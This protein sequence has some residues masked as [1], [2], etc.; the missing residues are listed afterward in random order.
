MK[1][2]MLVAA[3]ELSL[4]ADNVIVDCRFNLADKGE[5]ERLYHEGHI[6]GA[7]YMDLERHMS[8]PAG[9]HGGRHPLP[10]A[11]DFVA[12]LASF[13]IGPE[14]NVVAYDAHRLAYATRLW[15]MM[16]SLGYRPPRLLDGG[17]LAWVQAGGVPASGAE[18][19]V[20]PVETAPNQPSFMRVC[21]IEGLRTAQAQGATL[22]DSREPRRYAGVEEPIDPLAGHIPGALNHPWQGV[23]DDSGAV[24]DEAGLLAHWGDTLE[25][26]SLVVYCGS[27]VTAC[28]NLFSLALLGRDDAT[29]YAGSWSD[30]CSY[31]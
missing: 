19:A 17:Y 11:A 7:V 9:E 14:T 1:H 31:L 6:P 16:R 24:R 8:G 30:W 18:A 21:D 23:T 3:N 26:D 27:G 15:W 20:P 13:G 5:G 2:P 10:G 4:N 12:T 29:L 28:V 25:A 22:V